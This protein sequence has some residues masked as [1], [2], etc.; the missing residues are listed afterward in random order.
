MKLSINAQRIACLAFPN[1]PIQRLLVAKPE[2][3]RTVLLL[4]ENTTGG[5]VVRFCNRLACRRGIAAGMPL[6]EVQA[7][8]RARD[9][10]VA[11]PLQAEADREALAQIAIRC[12]RYS[13]CVGLE[14]GDYPQSALLNMTGIAHL[15]GG[16]SA[17]AEQIVRELTGIAYQTEQVTKSVPLLRRSSAGRSGL[18]GTACKQAVAH[19]GAH[20]GVQ[21]GAAAL[22]FDVRLAIGDTI[23]IAWAAAHFAVPSG[24]PV[25]IPA[26]QFD[27]LRELPLEALRLGDAQIKKLHRL[28]IRTIHQVLCLDRSLL[29]SRFGMEMNLRLDQFLGHR[30]EVIIPCRPTPKFQIEHWFEDGVKCSDIIEQAWSCLLQR[31]LDL[32]APR[33]LGVRQLL[34]RFVTD[35]RT[36]HDL[37]I[38]VCKAVADAR[39]LG[40]LLRLQ[41]ERLH[42]DAPLIGIYLEALET[43]PLDRPQQELFVHR[44]PKGARPLASLLNRLVSR[45]G[46][47]AVVRPQVLPDPIPERAVA[48][49]PITEEFLP[50]SPMLDPVHLPMDRPTCLFPQ[51]VSVQVIAVIPDGPPSV[52]FWHGLRYDLARHWGPE[53]IESGW[54]RGEAVC[55]DYYRVE[56]TEGRRFWLFRQ[57]EDQRWFLHGEVF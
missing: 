29:P 49:A 42:F 3:A 53:R 17:L 8:V 11:E 26:E 14:E 32:L 47:Q 12:E 19:N 51:P 54:W 52:L 13:P 55:R 22:H 1:W 10:V 4:T 9:T 16:E 38:R 6:T 39:H 50:S 35:T 33:Q 41:L 30:A 25:I 15:F 28:G 57:H 44:Q 45:L 40:D 5:E 56:T 43:S 27:S 18:A 37:T 21:Y 7:V 48:F 36:T 24:K 2:L 34:C 20:N 31:L 46:R 23:G